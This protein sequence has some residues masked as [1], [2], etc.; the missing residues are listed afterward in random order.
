MPTMMPTSRAV[1]YILPRT[2]TNGPKVQQVPKRDCPRPPK[3]AKNQCELP[4]WLS[5][6]DTLSATY[7]YFYRTLLW[8]GDACPRWW[9]R[10]SLVERV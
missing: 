7:F 3:P 6:S 1:W 5:C 2:H 8:V 9:P 4:R 10:S